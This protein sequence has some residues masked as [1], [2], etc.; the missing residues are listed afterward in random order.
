M[1]NRQLAVHGATRGGFGTIAGGLAGV[2]AISH[3]GFSVLVKLT[4]WRVVAG[5]PTG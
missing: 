3:V 2:P 1:S 4:L 5:V